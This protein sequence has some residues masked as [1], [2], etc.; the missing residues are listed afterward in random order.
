MRA[1]PLFACSRYRILVVGILW[2]I[3]GLVVSGSYA[4]DDIDS[5]PLRGQP[6][7]RVLIESF[8]PEIDRGG[9]ETKG[10]REGTT[11]EGGTEKRL[12]QHEALLQ[13]ARKRPG[14]VARYGLSQSVAS[15]TH[16]ACT[17]STLQ[18]APRPHGATHRAVPF[19][20]SRPL[21][22]RRKLL[23]FPQSCR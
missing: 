16:A 17:S 15:G 5:A 19:C 2:S 18:V 12:T 8:D 6:G 21:T 13:H 10:Q 1:R 14:A 7:V 3:V 23:G 22:L 4:A 20:R 11:Y 9:V